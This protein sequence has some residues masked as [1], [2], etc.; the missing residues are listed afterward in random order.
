MFAMDIQSIS[1]QQMIWNIIQLV[2]A[3]FKQF[4]VVCVVNDS[5]VKIPLFV[6]SGDVLIT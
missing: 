4:T 1:V 5:N 3:D 2:H 6:S